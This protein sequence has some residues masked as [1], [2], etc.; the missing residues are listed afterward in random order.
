MAVWKEYNFWKYEIFERDIE[1][2]ILPGFEDLVRLW[3]K[4]RGDR[5]APAWSDF[6]FHDFAGWHGR[7]VV[8]DIFYDPFDFRYR[9]FGEEVAERHQVDYSGKLCTELE[10]SGF[11]PVDD[12]DFYEMTG[13]KLLI[14][15]VSGM[16][17]RL[18]RP[19]VSTTFVEFPLSD[20]GEMATHSLAAMI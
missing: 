20:T 17:S 1:P 12:L 5:P 15:R 6:D 7:I 14:S 13:R 2:E 4:K 16:L 8:A 10:N 3:R 9:L 19:H 11:D 18:D